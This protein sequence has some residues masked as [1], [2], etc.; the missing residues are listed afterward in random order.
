MKRKS[1]ASLRLL[2]KYC[3]RFKRLEEVIKM[4]FILIV[5]GCWFKS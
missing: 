5:L 2:S 1:R 4:L 3:S